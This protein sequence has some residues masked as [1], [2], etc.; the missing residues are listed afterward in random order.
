MRV[1]V[2]GASGWI[3]SAVIPEL[4]GAGHQVI[5]LARSD[6]AAATVSASGAEVLRGSL[7]DLEVLRKGADSSEG[8]F[9][10]GFVHDFNNYDECNRID[11]AAIETM[12][13]ALESSGRPFLIASGVAAMREEGRAGTEED[14]ADP[15]FDRSAA[16]EMTV[17]LADRGVRSSVVRLPP[18]VHGSGDKGFVA[19]LVSIAREKGAAGY[20]GDGSNRWPAVHRSDAARLYRLALD[21]APAGSVLHAVAEE[22]VTG[23]AIAEAIGRQLDLPAVSVPAESA[24]DHFGWLGL[25]FGADLPTASTITR[26]M[27]GWKPTGPTLIEDLE[28][29]HYT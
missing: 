17:A 29:G 1:F 23:R 18:T 7:E 24:M 11:R 14:R 22:G 21:A 12:G 25:F 20:V 19:T 8:V 16:S 28:A 2:T 5:G 3:G 27:L 15:N 26:K 6:A 9:H 10:L 13:G 4:I